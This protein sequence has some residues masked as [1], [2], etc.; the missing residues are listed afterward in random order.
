[1]SR[2]TSV[3]RPFVLLALIVALVSQTV[4][5]GA[6]AQTDEIERLR[7]DRDDVRAE[8]ARAARD[9]DPLVAENDEIE[10]ALAL[11]T[12]E[13][14]AREAALA[15]TTSALAKARADVAT[16]E[17]DVL[18]AQGD[19]ADLRI[20]LQR[21]AITAY[22][23]PRAE[24]GGDEVLASADLNEGE[25]RRALMLAVSRSQN[26]ILDDM[27]AAEAR[28]EQAVLRAQGAEREITEREAEAAAQLAAV[29]EAIADQ[30]RLQDILTQ[31][32]A[33]YQGH[34]DGHSEEE[35]AI[36]QRIAGLIAEEEARQRAIEEAAR[37]KRERE[38]VAAEE[39][40]LAEVRRQQAAAGIVAET[41][42]VVDR[43]SAGLNGAPATTLSQLAWPVSGT[44]TS[45]FGPR[46]GRM[47]EGLD[48][49]ANT[50]TPVIAAAS[51]TVLSAGREGNYGNLVLINHGG[52]LV[53]AYAHLNAINVRAGQD[54]SVG[55]SV[56]TVGS[57]GNSSG[58]HLHFEVRVNN[59]PYDPLGY[60]G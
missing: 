60:L 18:V 48:V 14:A 41:P 26:D 57:T 34:V 3:L 1:M 9:L 2:T 53:T 32:I 22:M 44:I 8:R 43:A 56:G 45:R 58:P 50:G 30:A 27:R 6:V 24:N 46:W 11:L 42:N 39:A 4:V 12:D 20:Q 40:R 47:H 29:D 15:A 54:I 17:Q 49:A 36:T 37:I 35:D 59:V 13:R 33:E 21:Q 51:G 28:V 19:I 52:G 55:N 16:A 7:A 25:R 10:A 38:R 23:Q 5:G 31:R